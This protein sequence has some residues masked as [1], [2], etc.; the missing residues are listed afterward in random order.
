MEPKTER[1]RGPMISQSWG[2]GQA[3][4]HFFYFSFGSHFFPFGLLLD[5]SKDLPF[6]Y[7][8]FWIS[9]TDFDLLKTC[10]A[11]MSQDDPGDIPSG[12]AHPMT[13]DLAFQSKEIMKKNWHIK[14]LNAL[15]MK[16]VG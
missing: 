11:F 3:S 1:F 14:M 7:N 4:D 2:F 9:L 10:F 5:S 13:E 6:S 8:G 16:N 12:Q 15:A